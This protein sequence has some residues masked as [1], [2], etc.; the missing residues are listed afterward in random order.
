MDYR[1]GSVDRQGMD[2][3]PLGPCLKNVQGSSGFEA[4]LRQ[5]ITACLCES[6]PDRAARSCQAPSRELV[7][8][9]VISRENPTVSHLL[10]SHPD[11][12]GDC[13]K[14]IHSEVN[15]QKAF[16]S[17]REGE[18]IFID[19]VTRELGVA[20]S[21]SRCCPRAATAGPP[22]DQTEGRGPGPFRCC[23]ARTPCNSVGAAH[24]N[25]L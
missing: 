21:G 17:I 20:P 1:I 7:H 16:R 14:I 11:Y 4:A 18:D 13:W 19:P 3:R 24:R 22:C 10:I 6:H 15:A 9:G 25:I 2:N 23:I 8:L 5:E 12:G